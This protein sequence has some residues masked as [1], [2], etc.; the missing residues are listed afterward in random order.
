MTPIVSDTTK[1]GSAD[2]A[3]GLIGN[4]RQRTL[5]AGFIPLVDASVLIA[6]AEF[7]FAE[8]EGLTLDLVKDVSWANVR[9][10]LAFRQFD[11]AHMLSPM[12]VASMLDLGSN[13][14]PTITP[15]SLGRGG[16][17]ITLST[18]LFARMREVAGISETASALDNAK[19]LKTLL[20]EMRAR[21][22]P[23]PTF[24]VTYPF[25]S[26]N[27]EFR[28]WLAAGGIHPDKD[29]KLV[30]VPPP[31]TSD[32]LAAGAI[33]GFCV[34]AP[35]NMVASERGIGRI[36]AAK[37]DIWPSAPEKVVGMRPEWA[38][39]QPE[40]VSR[41]LV[42]LDAA[43]R[44]C[45]DA[46]NHNALAET[47]AKEKY[48]AAPVEIIRQVLAGRFSV[49]AQGNQRVIER[50]FTFHDN[51]A[52]YPRKSQAL[53]IYS[54][55]IRWGQ[56][57]FTPQAAEAAASAYRSDLYRDALGTGNSPQDAD[58][59]IEGDRDGDRFMDGNVF[60]PGAIVDYVNGFAVS[61]HAENHTG[62]DEA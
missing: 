61:A 21:G 36:V 11:I 53:W 54:Q 41:L 19:A 29:V 39:A 38:E 14:S 43:A 45:D 44:W 46:E 40:A 37:Q 33:D 42:A 47:L 9:D 24:G 34:G 6:A 15:F 20:D 49:D 5:R 22:E 52:N 8:R 57:Q 10:R 48:I 32:A 26:H 1:S 2:S 58:T 7:G 35:W 12:P 62:I 51:F 13:P 28:Y 56:A 30:V 16:N 60:D 18:R 3:P 23:A 4:D 25:S 55:M 17:A 27:Y 50:Y 31:L 59:R